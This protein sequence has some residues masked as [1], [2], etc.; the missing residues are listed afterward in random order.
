MSSHRRLNPLTGAWVVV[1]PQRMQ[2]PWQGA[3][4]PPV[5]ANVP[6]YD[7]ACYLCPGN[8][9]AGGQQNPSYTGTYVFAN[10]YPALV[11]DAATDALAG[12][13]QADDLLIAAPAQGVCRVVCYAPRHDLGIAQMAVPQVQQVLATWIA[14]TTELAALPYISSVQIFENRGSL[15]GASNPHPHGQIWATAHLPNEHAVELRQ[16]RSYYQQHGRTLLAAY[17]ERELAAAER[18]VCSNT[19]WVVVVPFWAV[20]PFETLL[21]PRRACGTLADLTTSE[22]ADLAAI[23]I[24]LNRAYDAMFG[25]PFAYSMGFHQCPLDGQSYPEWHLHAHFYPPLLRSASVRKFM[26]GYELLAEPQRDLT[27]EAAAQRL[28]DRAAQV[29]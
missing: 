22:Q 2:R 12:V 11:A 20:W 28:R 6:A 7:P 18:I 29:G 21:I 24:T 19:G 27:A 14:Q 10:D 15:M 9:R 25:V 13:G 1:S 23:L 17:L 4:E 5:A 16:Q 26:V 8:Q 3:E